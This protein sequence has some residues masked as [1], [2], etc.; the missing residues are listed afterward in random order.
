MPLSVSFL[1]HFN[2]ALTPYARVANLACYRGLLNVLRKWRR[3]RFTLHISGTL[4]ESLKQLNSRSLK[5]LRAGIADGQFELLGSTYAQNVMASSDEI[6]NRLQMEQHLETLWKFFR[7]Q[8]KGF[9]VPERCW[10]QAFVKLLK[11][12]GYRYTLV[13]RQTLEKSGTQN[14]YLAHRSSYGKSSLDIVNDD[15]QF[16]HKVNLAIWAGKKGSLLKPVMD[17]LAPLSD[18]QDAGRSLVVYAE[19][20][21]ASGLWGYLFGAFPQPVWE[22]WNLL[23]R[24]MNQDRRFKICAIEDFLRKQPDRE[25]IGKIPDGQA[26]WMAAALKSKDAPYHEDGYTDWFDF[27]ACAPKLKKYRPF[28]KNLARRI[29]K[30]ERKLLLFKQ[31]NSRQKKMIKMIPILENLL[32]QSKLIFCSHQYEF[33]CIGIGKKNYAPFDDAEKCLAP[34]LDIESIIVNPTLEQVSRIEY[35]Q[36]SRLSV[37]AL[38]CG[39]IAKNSDSEWRTFKKEV[40]AKNVWFK[41]HIAPWALNYLSSK[42]VEFRREAPQIFVP[43]K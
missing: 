30:T 20:A 26:E 24:E 36:S 41:N 3:T 31:K 42:V 25:A 34:L 33:G 18:R 16:K 27:N 6:S 17:H 10:K 28:F 21:E 4:I 9:W 12:F 39:W 37:N 32:K 29:R 15:E 19:D 7:V 43:E 40:G 2:Q 11:E 8:P 13:E 14:I 38:N 22:N 35:K 23:L 1:F 5:L